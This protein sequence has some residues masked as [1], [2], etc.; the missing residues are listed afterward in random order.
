MTSH[1]TKTPREVEWDRKIGKDADPDG[2][3][4]PSMG[5]LASGMS[6]K[7]LPWNVCLTEQSPLLGEN[8]FRNN[9]VLL[10]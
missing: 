3:P 7:L 4:L 10:Y 2:I 5:I 6:A 8:D 1:V 9:Y